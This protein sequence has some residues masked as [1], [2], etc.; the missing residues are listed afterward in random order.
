MSSVWSEYF[1][2]K[3]MMGKDAYGGSPEEVVIRA[4]PDGE[5]VLSLPAQPAAPRL[6]GARAVMPQAEAMLCLKHSFL[7]QGNT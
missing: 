1:P 5:V 4:R 6:P 2:L 7:L 3:A